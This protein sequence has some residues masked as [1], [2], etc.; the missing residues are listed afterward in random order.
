[1]LLSNPASSD[2]VLHLFVII[3]VVRKI[4]T[5]PCI[6]GTIDDLL[7]L[8]FLFTMMMLCTCE[9]SDMIFSQVP[10]NLLLAE[11][12]VIGCVFHGFFSLQSLQSGIRNDFILSFEKRYMYQCVEFYFNCF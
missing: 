4:T 10:F 2:F 8:L 9:L 6:T 5:Q 7:I 3:S 11:K 12:N 1:M